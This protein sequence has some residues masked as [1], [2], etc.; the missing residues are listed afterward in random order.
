MGRPMWPPYA[1]LWGRLLPHSRLYS[2]HESPG[3]VTKPRQL[4]RLPMH[5]HGMRPYQIN[6]QPRPPAPSPILLHA[7]HAQQPLHWAA[8]LGSS[9]RSQL[10]C[11]LFRRQRFPAGLQ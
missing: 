5:G 3:G 7:L 1:G 2:G 6:S 4:A 9:W 11:P 8:S 10:F